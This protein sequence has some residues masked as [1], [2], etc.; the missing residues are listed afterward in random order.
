M[1]RISR[2]LK[3]ARN[4]TLD[5]S[6][7]KEMAELQEFR[8]WTISAVRRNEVREGTLTLILQK[9]DNVR[10]VALFG[11]ELGWWFKTRKMSPKAVKPVLEAQP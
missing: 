9:G 11:T 10:E 5:L 7:T 4:Q 6:Y 2:E 1:S 3:H 8:G